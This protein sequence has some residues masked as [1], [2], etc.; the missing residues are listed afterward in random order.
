MG[1]EFSIAFDIAVIAIPAVFAFVGLK[2]GFAKVVLGLISTLVAFVLAWTL[3]APIANAIYKGTIE[4]PVEEQIDKVAKDSFGEMTFGA[5]SDADFSQ[6]KINGVL[7]GDIEPDYAGTR[8]TAVDLSRLDLSGTGITNEDFLKIGIV[9]TT[10]LN[11]L[12]AKTAEFSMDDI[13]KYGLG[14]LAV[15]HYIAVNLVKL[16]IMKGFD[17]IAEKV[18]KYLPGSTGG[19]SSDSKGISLMRTIAVKMLDTRWGFKEAVM[20]GIV[21][22]NCT[23]IIRTAAFAVIFLLVLVGLRIVSVAAKLVNK[24]PVIGKINSF[25]GLILGLIEGIIA[26]FVVCIGIR[27]AVSLTG[28]NM[29]L[30]N[31]TTID[32]TFLFKWFYNFEFLNFIG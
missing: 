26:V 5:I 21:K 18:G 10:D 14:K 12:N 11:K 7:V 16:P 8:K 20:N 22:P 3:S 32:A 23:L 27:L 9:N 15:A 25:L 30:F 2:R 29:I 19:S 28:A 6:V 4:K 24:M 17:S 1:K 13:E 31:Q